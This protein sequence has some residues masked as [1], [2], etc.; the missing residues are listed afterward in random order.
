[1]KKMNVAMMIMA[2]TAAVGSTVVFASNDPAASGRVI[3]SSGGVLIQRSVQTDA[4]QV[5]SV[6][7]VGDTVLTTDTGKAQWQM[8][9]S[10]LFAIAPETGFKINKYAL[11]SAK[12]AEG[13]ASYTLL[14]GSVHTITGKIGKSVAANAASGTYTAASSRFNEAN[15]KK[16][17]AAPNGPYTLKTALAVITTKGADFTA[18]Q[19]DKILKVLVNAGSA[20]VC[21]VA[22]CETSGAGEAIVVSC[23]GCKPTTTSALS[24]GIDSVVAGLEFNLQ[25]PAPSDLDDPNADPRKKPLTPTQACRTV[26][27]RLQGAANCQNADG[28]GGPGT[29]VSPN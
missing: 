2:M 14:Q 13:V 6:I 4:A 24:L 27:A 23:E 1:M 20:T 25:I 21:T 3:S 22:G 9:D 18:V 10:S 16:V 11:P 15:L 19:A 5:G 29:P 8:S 7:G 17:V 28:V 26:L 12:N